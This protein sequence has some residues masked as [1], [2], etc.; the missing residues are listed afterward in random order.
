MSHVQ[1]LLDLDQNPVQLDGGGSTPVQLPDAFRGPSVVITDYQASPFGVDT[2]PAQHDNLAP[3]L[4]KRLRDQGDIDELAQVLIHAREQQGSLARLC[5]TAVPVSTYMRYR[6]WSAQHDDHVLL[7]P[8]PEALLALARQQALH[9]GTLIFIHDRSIDLL[10]LQDG[11]ILSAGRMHLFSYDSSEYQRLAR[12]ISD[13]VQKLKATSASVPCVL[14]EATTGESAPLQFALAAYQLA[15]NTSAL[16]ATRLF[17]ALKLGQADLAGTSRLMYLAQLTLPIAAVC[18]LLLCLLSAGLAWYWKQQT[19][20]LQHALTAFSHSD[21]VEA[22]GPALESALQE[23]NLLVQSQEKLKQ[24]MAIAERA[25]KTPDP[26]QLMQHLRTAAT[27]DIEL[28]EVN[29]LSDEREVLIIVVGRSGGIAAP[30]EAETR[31]VN[32]LNK[33]GYSVVRREIESEAGKSL[34]RLALIWSAK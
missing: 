11:M 30:L 19:E 10:V 27:G 3:L 33:Q 4:E 28:T 34:F 20:D 23:A 7:F 31:F 17:Q 32:A 5:Y 26:A 12:H 9:D 21:S 25:R 16:P 6:N 24:F 15:L 18:M 1:Y 8:L 13:S 2:L 29:I 22:S 14:V